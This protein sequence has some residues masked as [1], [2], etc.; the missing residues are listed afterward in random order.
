M[1]KYHYT[2][3]QTFSNV[4]FKLNIPVFTLYDNRVEFETK[5]T[6]RPDSDIISVLHEC[7]LVDVFNQKHSSG[8]IGVKL[9][10]RKMQKIF[11]IYKKSITQFQLRIIDCRNTFE[12]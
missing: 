8:T 6:P 7:V 2:D 12:D 1:E 11:L 4:H 10:S 3:K 9:E 5:F